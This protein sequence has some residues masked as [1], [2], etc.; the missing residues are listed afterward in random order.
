M[1]VHREAAERLKPGKESQAGK[2][3]LSVEGGFSR[4]VLGIIDATVCGVHRFADRMLERIYGATLLP[5]ITPFVL[6]S[7]LIHGSDAL[8]RPM[9]RRRLRWDVADSSLAVRGKRGWVNQIVSQA[10]VPMLLEELDT[11]LRLNYQDYEAQDIDQ[12]FM[13]LGEDEEGDASCGVRIVPGTTERVPTIVIPTDW[14]FDLAR[15]NVSEGIKLLVA[16]IIHDSTDD[17]CTKHHMRRVPWLVELVEHQAHGTMAWAD[18][19]P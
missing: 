9:R 2:I 1:D 10:G 18:R 19:R 14:E 15:E 5:P 3:A 8:I 12:L 13:T 16:R 7:R 17:Q 11:G 6:A 4:G